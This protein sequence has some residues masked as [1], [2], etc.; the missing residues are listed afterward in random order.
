[1]VHAASYSDLIW[2]KQLSKS[3]FKV[4]VQII[5]VEVSCVSHFFQSIL[6]HSSG[7]SGFKK[8][9]NTEGRKIRKFNS[10]D[11]GEG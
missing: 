7:F 2:Y 10:L 4:G 1:M 5:G 11:E 9:Y 8:Q 6:R 3:M